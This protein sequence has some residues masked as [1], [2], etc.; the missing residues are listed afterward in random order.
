MPLSDL[1]D[2]SPSPDTPIACDLSV[3]DDPETHRDHF[4]ALFEEREEIRRVDGGLAVRF[5]G[6]M[7]VA[8]RILDF[9][10]RERQCCPFLTFEV[11]FEPEEGGV[12]LYMGGDERVEDYITR[13]F[14]HTWLEN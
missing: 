14:E 11:A 1:F 9:I 8:D 7:T 12:W 2:P 4:E 5:P 3:L 10:R 6:T 13:E